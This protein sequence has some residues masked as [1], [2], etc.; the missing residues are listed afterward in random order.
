MMEKAG[1]GGG[2][3]LIRDFHVFERAYVVR[4]LESDVTH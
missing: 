3:G 4:A 2:G 1:G